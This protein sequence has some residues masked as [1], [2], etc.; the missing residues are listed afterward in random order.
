MNS[1]V[2]K[3]LDDVVTALSNEEL[4]ERL[5]LHGERRSADELTFD[6]ALLFVVDELATDEP[7]ELVGHVL[8]DEIELTA[9]LRL[10]VALEQLASVIGDHGTFQDAVASG[11]PWRHV[12]AAAECVRIQLSEHAF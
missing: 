5:W 1:H 8:V 6:D 11:Q 10:S 7:D 2:R 4:H 3:R 12:L 9:F